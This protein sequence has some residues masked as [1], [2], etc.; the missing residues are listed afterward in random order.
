MTSKWPLELDLVKGIVDANSD[1]RLLAFQQGFLDEKGPN[2]EQH[3]LGVMALV[4]LDP[5]NVKAILTNT[6]SNKAEL[7]MPAVSHSMAKSPR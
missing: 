3:M 1:Q 4:T 6:T 7:G 2:L 5:E